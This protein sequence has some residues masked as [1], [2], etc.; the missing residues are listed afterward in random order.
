MLL[1]FLVCYYVSGGI[2]EFGEFALCGGKYGTYHA[3]PWLSWEL[4][5]GLPG[6]VAVAAERARSARAESTEIAM[7]GQGK[8]KGRCRF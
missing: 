7:Y 2:I 8:R 1:A 6:A 5:L 3:C 4:A